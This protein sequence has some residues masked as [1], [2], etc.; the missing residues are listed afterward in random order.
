MELERVICG[1]SFVSLW[2][3]QDK[4]SADIVIIEDKK[5]RAVIEVK[6]Y[7]SDISKDLQR[8]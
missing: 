3:T 6:R 1:K 7:G 5:P 8:F 4:T 2:G